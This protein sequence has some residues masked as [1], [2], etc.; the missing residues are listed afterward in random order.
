MFHHVHKLLAGL[1]PNAERTVLTRLLALYGA[2]CLQRHIGL[3]Y[4]GGFAN[5]PAAARHYKLG[6]L[7]LLT[8]LKDD[9]VALVDTVAPTDFVLNS[10]LGRADGEMYRH[11]EA[12]MVAQPRAFERVDWWEDVVH[13]RRYAEPPA[14][15]QA[16]L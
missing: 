6:I 14:P 4:E 3:L 9:A 15:V 12:Q 8:L 16:K 1:A 11:L 5:G 13:W 7:R 10:P 2:G